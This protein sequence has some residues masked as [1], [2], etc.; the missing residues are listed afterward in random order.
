MGEILK[1]EGRYSESIEWCKLSLSINNQNWG[2]YHCLGNSS[3]Q[4]GE[5]IKAIQYYLQSIHINPHSMTY[6]NL[7]DCFSKLRNTISSIRCFMQAILIDY[8][9]FVSYITLSDISQLNNIYRALINSF[10]EKLKETN[11]QNML[12]KFNIALYY[13]LS[14][15]SYR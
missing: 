1:M 4:L 6:D 2:A 5:I 10:M 13:Y 3:Y 14:K 9:S 8:D 11:P 7:G 15:Q 12:I